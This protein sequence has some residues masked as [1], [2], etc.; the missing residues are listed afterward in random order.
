VFSGLRLSGLSKK[1]IDYL[2][3]EE[4]EYMSRLIKEVKVDLEGYQT[5]VKT[6][7]KFI[8]TLK[9]QQHIPMREMFFM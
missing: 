9:I 6:L 2:F 7:K 4:V 3:D 5:N 1:K 8:K